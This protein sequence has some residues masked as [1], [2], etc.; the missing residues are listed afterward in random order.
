MVIQYGESYKRPTLFAAILV[1]TSTVI[2][3]IS[4]SSLQYPIRIEDLLQLESKFK[5]S[6]LSF[7]P[8]SAPSN[9]HSIVLKLLGGL[10]LGLLFIAL[11]RKFERRFRH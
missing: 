7:F 9:W 4:N 1:F 3:S 11:R 10:T 2:L 6:V 8:F 5:E